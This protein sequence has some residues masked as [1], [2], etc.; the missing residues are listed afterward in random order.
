MKKIAL[1]LIIQICVLYAFSQPP[2][3]PGIAER[4]KRTKELL[5]TEVKLSNSQIAVIEKEFKQFFIQADKLREDNPPPPNEKVKQALERLED[6][7]DNKVKSSL[8]A[9]QYK[10]YLSVV[11]RLHP[12]R[13]GERSENGPPPQRQ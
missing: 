9:E 8:S 11:S 1:F 7:R 4:L 6:D 12:P 10:K 13:P 5:N 3:P 2:K